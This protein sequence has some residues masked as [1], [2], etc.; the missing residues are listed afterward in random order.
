MKKQS[1]SS[2]SKIVATNTKKRKTEV[3][4]T[5]DNAKSGRHSVETGPAPY[6]H[7][8]D[9]FICRIQDGLEVQPPGGFIIEGKYFVVAHAPLKM[10]RAGTIII[11]SRRHL[12]D[13]SEMTSAE[14]EEFFLIVKRLVPAIK[15]VAEAPR[16][17]FLAFM[18]HAPH[19]HL[20]LVPRKKGGR[21]RG[22]PYLAQPA[23]ATSHRSAEVIA[24]KIEKQFG[25][26]L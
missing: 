13:F 24:K 22:L 2:A 25:R 18:E 23:V 20:W 21:I 6:Y 14:S 8:S 9:C 11:L 3:F 15:D 26:S 7:R 4:I 5:P 12:L 10:A 16:V 19:F 17:Y 1:V